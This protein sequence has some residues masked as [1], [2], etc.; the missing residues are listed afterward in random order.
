MNGCCY[1]GTEPLIGISMATAESREMG[2]VC[3]YPGAATAVSPG[4]LEADPGFEN[5]RAIPELLE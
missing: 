4:R 2:L 3:R 1:I 5:L